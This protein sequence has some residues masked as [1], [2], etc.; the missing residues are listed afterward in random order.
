[1]A[2][3]ETR[4]IRTRKR[5][6]RSAS[7]RAVKTTLNLPEDAAA[8]LRALAED[9]NTTFAEVI[10]RAL[11]LDKYLHDVSRSGRRILVENATD[12]TLTEIVFF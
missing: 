9:R 4:Q 11:Y 10:R 2:D 6:V 5:S 7:Q 3:P 8:A 1:M 12:K